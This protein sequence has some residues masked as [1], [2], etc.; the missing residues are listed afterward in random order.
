MRTT[1]TLDDDVA[2]SL[3]RLRKAGS[4]SLKEI[5]NEALRYGLE[6]M[7][8]PARRRK[9]FRTRSVSVGRCLVGNIDNIAKVVAVAER[10]S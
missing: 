7:S 2:A 8:R 5:V 6:Q 1:L 9:R 10:E 4:R 3:E